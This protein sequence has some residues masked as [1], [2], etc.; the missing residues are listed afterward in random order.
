MPSSAT[1]T[2]GAFLLSPQ[3]QLSSLSR[4]FLVISVPKA[5][6]RLYALHYPWVFSLK[7]VWH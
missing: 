1:V 5:T 3:E 6:G 7:S 2:A 4:A